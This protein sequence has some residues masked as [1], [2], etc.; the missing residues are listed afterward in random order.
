MQ[1]CIQASACMC[2]HYVLCSPD[3][4]LLAWHV[5]PVITVIIRVQVEHNK[6]VDVL[7]SSHISTTSNTAG[8]EIYTPHSFGA[9]PY[10][11]GYHTEEQQQVGRRAAVPLHACRPWIA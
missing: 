10:G 4:S 7:F 6:L 9:I 3:A 2:R 1:H 8:N 5:Q 11:R